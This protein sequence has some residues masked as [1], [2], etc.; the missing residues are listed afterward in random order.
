MPIT[1]PEDV[2]PQLVGAEPEL[3][4]RTLQARERVECERVAGDPWR[5]ERDEREEREDRRADDDGRIAAHPRTEAAAGNDRDNGSSGIGDD[6]AH[7]LST[8]SADRRTRS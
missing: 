1:T 3:R 8:G 2:A 6:G 7:R 4:R 5:G